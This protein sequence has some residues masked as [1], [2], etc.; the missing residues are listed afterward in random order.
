M[1]ATSAEAAAP[2]IA[3]CINR[4][5]EEEVTAAADCDDDCR[6]RHKVTTATIAA[7]SGC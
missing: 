6:Y 5:K 1:T 7:D 4:E 3:N 2:E